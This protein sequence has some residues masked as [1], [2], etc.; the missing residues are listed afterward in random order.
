M[1]KIIIKFPLPRILI[2][3]GAFLTLRSAEKLLKL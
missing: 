3:F 2:K 1:N